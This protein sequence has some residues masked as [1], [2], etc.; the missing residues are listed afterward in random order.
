VVSVSFPVH[1]DFTVASGPTTE[2]DLASWAKEVGVTDPRKP[3][4]WKLLV[5]AIIAITVMAGLAQVVMAWLWPMPTPIQQ[6]VFEAMG[7]A[8]KAGLGVLFAS[9]IS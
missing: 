6:S 7:F 2:K 9:K 5:I 8:W 3:E 1:V 4:R